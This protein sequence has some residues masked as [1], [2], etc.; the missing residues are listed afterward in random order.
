VSNRR[1]INIEGFS[2]G[3]LPI[4]AASRVGPLV[5]TGG[6]HGMDPATGKLPED[7]HQQTERMFENLR[8]IMTAAGGSLEHIAGVTIFVAVPDARV[9]VNE[10][11][12]RAFPDPASRPARHMIVDYNLPGGLVVQCAATAWI[13]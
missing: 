1:S 8:R 3:Q 13:G 9:A 2:H 6:V 11:W 12:V 10:E 5:V 7:V 4:P